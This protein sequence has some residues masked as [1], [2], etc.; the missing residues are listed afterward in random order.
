MIWRDVYMQIGLSNPEVLL[1]LLSILISPATSPA[2]S[3]H[4]WFLTRRR[5]T[6]M[7]AGFIMFPMPALFAKGSCGW[8]GRS[9]VNQFCDRKSPGDDDRQLLTAN[10]HL[11]NKE[12]GCF[13][14]GLRIFSWQMWINS[15][16]PISWIHP[17]KPCCCLSEPHLKARFLASHLLNHNLP[18]YLP[19]TPLNVTFG[20]ITQC[21]YPQ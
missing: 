3:Y 6:Q 19:P 14:S 4:S 16:C 7:R 20:N 21:S 10:R 12:N 9:N 1:A 18:C 11:P 8:R 5:E 13:S 17:Y 2:L 15:S